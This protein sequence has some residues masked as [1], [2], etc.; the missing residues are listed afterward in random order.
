MSSVSTTSA[1]R[2]CH[3]AVRHRR[4]SIPSS[5]QDR[6]SRCCRM[7]ISRSRK[8]RIAAY[9][10]NTHATR[11]N[12]LIPTDPREYATWLEW[13]FY[14]ATELDATSLYVM[15]RHGALRHIYG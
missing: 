9:L 5:I 2:S 15:R 12:A 11:E 4:R 10:S 6:K 3:V 8:A 1:G 7:A 13:C 14:A